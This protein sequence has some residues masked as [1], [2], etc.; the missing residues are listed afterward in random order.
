M[1]DDN[2]VVVLD[3]SRDDGFVKERSISIRP[4]LASLRRCC[5]CC[6]FIYDDDNNDDDVIPIY[7]C[8]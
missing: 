5:C 3:S 8:T 2:D 7:P 4:I 6:C 1:D